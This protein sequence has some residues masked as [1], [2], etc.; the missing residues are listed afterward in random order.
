[1]NFF[2]HSFL[3]FFLTRLLIDRA[4]LIKLVY[5][6]SLAE[7]IV[8]IYVSFRYF[9]WGGGIQLELLGRYTKGTTSNGTTKR[10][11]WYINQ[12]K[13]IYLDYSMQFILLI[14]QKNVDGE[15]LIES[16]Q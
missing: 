12:K 10:G 6:T 4:T 7:F 13:F 15:E 9:F 3:K 5:L 11:L 14:I 1:M 2:D 8:A 16:T